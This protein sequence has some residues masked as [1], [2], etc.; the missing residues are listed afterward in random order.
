VAESKSIITIDVVDDKF[1]EFAELFEK[2]KAALDEL[3]GKWQKVCKAINTDGMKAAV[4]Q[5][6]ALRITSLGA[7]KA[8]GIVA[9]NTSKI[10]KSVKEATL[11]M[12]KWVGLG[13]LF[14][15]GV[16]GAAMLFD[17]LALTAG[18]GRRESQGLGITTGEHRAEKISYGRVVDVDPLLARI[19]AMQNSIAENYKFGLVGLSQNEF[20]KDKTA[21]DILPRLLPALQKLFK[22]TG[23][24]RELLQARGALDFLSYEEL[25]RLSKFTKEELDGL[26]K[27]N[28]A[29][30]K[31]LELSD[32]T[33][34]KWQDMSDSLTVAKIQ[35]QTVLIDGL[36]KVAPVLGKISGSIIKTVETELILGAVAVKKWLAP[37]GK[38]ESSGKYKLT[39]EN[40]NKFSGIES[41]YGLPPGTLASIEHTES[42]GKLDAISPKG[43]QGPFQFMPDTAKQYGLTNPQDEM[44]AADAAGR[45]M[46]DMLKKYHGDMSKALAAYNEGPGNVDKGRMPAETRDYV[47]KTLPPIT[48]TLNNQTGGNVFA[49]VNGLSPQ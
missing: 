39:P 20:G 28:Q 4:K 10:A 48:I 36:A 44:Q 49:T 46:R 25:T 2:Y 9:G 12:A 29:R 42:R 45:Y 17:R 13:G 32:E 7:G 37:N 27:N 6:E 16:A 40:G 19:N 38:Q 3:P 26:E 43:A 23:G 35:V 5:Q 34:R 18:E 30:R 1:K 21:A 47:A 15:G 22:E 33:Q 14:A 41:K 11:G 8:T 31:E 24:K